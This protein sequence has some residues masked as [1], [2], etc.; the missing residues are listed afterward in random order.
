MRRKNWELCTDACRSIYSEIRSFLSQANHPEFKTE[1]VSNWGNVKPIF[2]RLFRKKG[3]IEERCQNWIREINE[4]GFGF[5][6][7][8]AERDIIYDDREWFRGAVNVGKDDQGSETYTRIGNFQES[9]WKLF[10]DA[11]AS[12]RF[13]VLQEL[14]PPQGIICG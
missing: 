14:L 13:F 7:Q 2:S 10:H 11:A 1:E 3:T 4:S 8:Y 12:H 9:D 5:N 6:C